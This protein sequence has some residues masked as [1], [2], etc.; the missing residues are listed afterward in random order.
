[1]TESDVL[2]ESVVMN[3]INYDVYYRVQTSADG[4]AKDIRFVSIE[5]DDA[6]DDL[7][8]AFTIDEIHFF[9]DYLLDL[10]HD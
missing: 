1:M 3:D 5:Y 8:S 4:A 2:L 9:K 10:H 7:T 6:S